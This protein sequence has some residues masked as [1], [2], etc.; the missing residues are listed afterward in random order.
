MN[1]KLN[2]Y[3]PPFPFKWLCKFQ[4]FRGLLGGNWYYNRYWWDAGS[5]CAFWWERSDLGTVGGSACTIKSEQGNLHN[6]EPSF[7]LHWL[8]NLKSFRRFCGGTWHHLQYFT[9]YGNAFKR[10]GR[11]EGGFRAMLIETE[12]Y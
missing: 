9:E 5:S 1:N 10:W 7:P 3:M 11:W 8:T 12:K 6:W 4:F 2:A